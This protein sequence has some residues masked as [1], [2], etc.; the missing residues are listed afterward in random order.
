M[1]AI[2]VTIIFNN[3][4]F[5][6]I[7][8]SI[9]TGLQ[10]FNRS[11]KRRAEYR[12]KIDAVNEFMN[13]NGV[14]LQLRNEI[15]DYFLNIWLPRHTDFNET[16]LMNELP[17]YLR[18]KVMTDITLGVIIGSR[19]FKKYF[20]PFRFQSQWSHIKLWLELTADCVQPMYYIPYQSIVCQGDRGTEFFILKEGKVSV[21]INSEDGSQKMVATL[22]PGAYFGDLSLLGITEVRSATI[23]TLSNVTLYM[24]TKEDFE[25]ILMSM[26][27]GGEWL[28]KIMVGVASNYK[29]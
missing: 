26:P 24:L 7:L 28:R 15:R 16:S 23:Q 13:D 17:N 12:I 20:E 3:G 21:L 6:F 11:W 9:I 25:K 22:G 4:F 18:Q 27:D 1:N 29:M 14:S 10:D 8:A 19:F 2:V 5:A